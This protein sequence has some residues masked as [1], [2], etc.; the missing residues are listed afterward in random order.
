MRFNKD[1]L[2]SKGKKKINGAILSADIVRTFDEGNNWIAE[3]RNIEGGWLDIL[4]GAVGRIECSGSPYGSS[5]S[6]DVVTTKNYYGNIYFQA[7][8]GAASGSFSWYCNGLTNGGSWN[9]SMFRGDNHSTEHAR[10]YW[11]TV[12]YSEAVLE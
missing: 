2:F 5:T 8:S 12:P 11:G 3:A 1:L 10:F 9:R 4:G 7:V 6:V